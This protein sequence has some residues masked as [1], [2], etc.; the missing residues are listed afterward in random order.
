MLF[1][2]NNNNNHMIL[3]GDLLPP[4]C[5][6]RESRRIQ[7]RPRPLRVCEVVVIAPT[8][9]GTSTKAF[10]ALFMNVKVSTFVFE[11]ESVP[12]CQLLIVVFGTI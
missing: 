7:R 4:S 6:R 1:Y 12:W 3:T 10:H 11:T 5:L 9:P 8:R 2:D